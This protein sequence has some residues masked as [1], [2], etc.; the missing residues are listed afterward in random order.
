MNKLN[1]DILER[2]ANSPEFYEKGELMY[3]RAHTSY[4]RA[5][6]AAFYDAVVFPNLIR[7]ATLLKA[8]SN[9]PEDY[10]VWF[11]EPP[12]EGWIM[13]QEDCVQEINDRFIDRLLEDIWYS[14]EWAYEPVS[15]EQI[16]AMR[17]T[18][19][20]ARDRQPSLF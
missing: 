11:S 7:A 15:A 5:R 17:K 18:L 10:F 2:I 8:L 13:Q 6:E 9:L 19:V 4:V 3:N 14:E 20:L 1:H 12:N 16:A